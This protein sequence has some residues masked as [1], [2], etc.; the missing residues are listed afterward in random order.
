MKADG[1]IRP[2]YMVKVQRRGWDTVQMLEVV[3]DPLVTS[4]R[5]LFAKWNSR[6]PEEPWSN[7]EVDSVC[8]VKYYKSLCGRMCVHGGVCTNL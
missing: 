1:D 7:R 2:V 4:P 5:R 6:G 3:R 8:W